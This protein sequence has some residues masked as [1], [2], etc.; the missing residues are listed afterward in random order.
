M[1][2]LPDLLQQCH[3]RD[4]RSTT[5][6]TSWTTQAPASCSKPRVPLCACGAARGREW[7]QVLLCS[8]SGRHLA[9]GW[10]WLVL[11]ELPSCSGRSAPSRVTASTS[12]KLPEPALRGL[13][14]STAPSSAGTPT[15][16]RNEGGVVDHT[17]RNEVWQD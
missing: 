5:S 11:P 4:F 3:T 14:G 6:C 12:Y 8:S 13:Q 9:R 2:G 16:A 15:T 7:D 17:G 1:G 10:L